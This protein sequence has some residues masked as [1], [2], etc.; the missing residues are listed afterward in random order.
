MNSDPRVEELWQGFKDALQTWADKHSVNKELPEIIVREAIEN[1]ILSLVV[2]TSTCRDEA[3]KTVIRMGENIYEWL[4]DY[5]D[6]EFG[7]YD[8]ISN[9][10]P[11]A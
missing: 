2:S 10:T 4:N 3:Q 7:R 9:Y 5:S 1:F 6:I 8:Q 11:K